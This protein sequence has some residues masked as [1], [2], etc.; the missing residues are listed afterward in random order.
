MPEEPFGS[1]GKKADVKKPPLKGF[2]LNACSNSCL[3]L[4]YLLCSE[5]HFDFLC[6]KDR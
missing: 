6:L 2:E 3:L 4:S 1:R 5:V